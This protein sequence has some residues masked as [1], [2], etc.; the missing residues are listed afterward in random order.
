MNRFLPAT[1]SGKKSSGDRSEEEKK[2]VKIVLLSCIACG[3]F[4]T[5]LSLENLMWRTTGY[6]PP[7]LAGVRH[8]SDPSLLTLPAIREICNTPL[9]QPE[10]RIK[11]GVLYLRCGTP[12]LEGVW[13]I[14]KYE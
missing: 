13:R 2:M 6:Y 8:V 11:R 3:L 4:M 9:T 12:G 10:L 7:L 1:Y 5:F 14:E